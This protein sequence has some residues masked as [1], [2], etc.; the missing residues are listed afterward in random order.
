MAGTVAASGVGTASATEST[1]FEQ[2][3]GVVTTRGHYDTTWYGDVYVT[4]GNDRTNYE[5]TGTVP[6]VTNDESPEELIVFVHGWKHDAVQAREKFRQVTEA[7]RGS[8][9]T[10]P[11]V[12]YS[13]DSDGETLEWWDQVDVADRNAD[14]LGTFV[15]DLQAASPETDVRVIAHSLG[16]KTIAECLEFFMDRGYDTSVTSVDLLGGA[17]DDD[18]VATDGEYG[19]AIADHCEQFRNYYKTDDESLKYD[20]RAAMWDTAVGHEGIEGEAPHNYEEY[21][22]SYVESHDDY[23]KRDVGCIPDVVGNWE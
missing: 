12:G 4:D 15:R 21:D 3:S 5:T 2:Y 6:G 1:F 14:K 23:P 13:W 9:V 20:Y 11:V 17:I 8:D 18:E 10:A 7:L 16:A 22:V 19:Q